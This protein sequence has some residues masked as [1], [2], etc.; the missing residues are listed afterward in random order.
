MII[1]CG[2]C[3]KKPIHKWG[4]CKDCFIEYEELEQIV[5]ENKKLSSPKPLEN[6]E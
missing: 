4:L 2:N 1:N 3:G 5:K 6:R